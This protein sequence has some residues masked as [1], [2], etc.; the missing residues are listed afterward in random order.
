M[1]TKRQCNCEDWR[2]NIKEIDGAFQFM[3]IHNVG[4]YKGKKFVY[5][6]WCG[7]KL[8]ELKEADDE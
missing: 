1:Y 8:F 5:C 4:G 2:N 7:K 3:A 6:P